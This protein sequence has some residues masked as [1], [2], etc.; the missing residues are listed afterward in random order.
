MLT[1]HALH[2]PSWQERK[3]LLLVGSVCQVVVTTDS[4]LKPMSMLLEKG[5]V[6]CVHK[7]VKSHLNSDSNYSHTLASA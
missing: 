5:N 3:L 4:S 1:C 2:P 6:P 7:P